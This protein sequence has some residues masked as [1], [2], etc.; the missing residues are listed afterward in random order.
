MNLQPYLVNG[1]SKHFC[2]PYLFFFLID[3]SSIFSSNPILP[4][5][6]MLLRG[7]MFN[8][9]FVLPLLPLDWV[10]DCN[11]AWHSDASWWFKWI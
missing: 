1:I 9:Y 8:P 7:I 11:S 4:V 5:S 2:I 6:R 10:C 3:K